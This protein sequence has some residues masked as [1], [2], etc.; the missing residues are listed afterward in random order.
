MIKQLFSNNAIALLKYDLTPS[1]TSLIVH[2]GFG[3][4]FPLPN[5][6]NQ[7]FF[8]VT[9]E[10]VDAPL[11][12]EIIKISGRAG[13]VFQII[14]RGCEGTTP[15]A[16]L[17]GNETL[18]DHR[19]TADTIKQAFLNPV[20]SGGAGG[21]G[22]IESSVPVLVESAWNLDVFSSSFTAQKRSHKYWVTVSNPA[23]GLAQTFEVLAIIQGLMGSGAQS[24]EWTRHNR[25][26]YNFRGSI[27]LVLDTVNNLLIIK[28]LNNEPAQSVEVT[29]SHLSL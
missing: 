15:L 18:V 19:L 28:W 24:V 13:D 2:D 27:D 1:S 29:V 22:S 5:Q 12:R 11:V 3:G 4:V 26:G 16:W 21:S 20:S 17:G 14:E 23:S 9:L 6:I 7:E 25:V 8:L 10:S